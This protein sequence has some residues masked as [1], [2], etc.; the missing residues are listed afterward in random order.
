MTDGI[1]LLVPTRGRPD[2]LQ[3]FVESARGTAD[4][5]DLLEVVVYV[6]DDD[7]SYRDFPIKDI[8]WIV[9]PRIVLSKMWNECW[10]RAAGPIFG[11]MG[12]DIIFRTPHWDTKV[13]QA[14]ERHEDRIALVHGRDG[15]H[16]QNLGTHGFL[17]RNWTDAVGYF[18]P[19]YFSSDYNDTWLND[20]ADRINRRVFVP[21]IY[22]EHMHPACGKGPLD[23]THADRL[24]RHAE[25]RVDD[26]Y[27][28][29]VGERVADADKLAAVM[30]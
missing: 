23:Q 14:F 28:E 4:D 24:Q 10:L 13:R 21:E 16:D 15:M 25:D 19:P 20:V 3:R 8:H 7:E 27:R 9:G 2:G 1:S 29:L 26:K 22:T 18:V 12:D 5:P 30:S 6:D 17:H 11:H